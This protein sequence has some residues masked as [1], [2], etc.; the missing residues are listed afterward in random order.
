MNRMSENRFTKSGYRHLAAALVLGVV[1]LCVYYP[2]FRFDYLYHDDWPLFASRESPCSPSL[3]AWDQMGRPG[4]RVV[5]CALYRLFEKIDEAWLA[6]LA[7]VGGIIAFALLQSIYFQVL[8]ISW[9]A[10]VALAFG[11]SVLPGMLVFGYWITAGSIIFS[12][13]PCAAAALLTHASLHPEKGIV[14]RAALISGACALQTVSLLI[15]QAGAMYF[16]TL[17]AVMLAALLSRGLRAAV[18]PLA[19]FTLVG[20]GPMAGYFIWF[21]YLSGWAP[22]L[23]VQDPY[24]GRIFSELS[25][26]ANWF[27]SS[28]LPRAGLLWFF[29]LSRGFGLA[30]LTVFVV[31]LLLLSAYMWLTTWRW[32]DRTGSFLYAAY[33]VVIVVLGVLAFLPMLVTSLYLELFRSFIPL[34]AL[35]FLT[36]TIHLGTILRAASWAPVI[37]TGVAACFVLGLSCLAVDSLVSRMILPAAAEY[38]FVRNSLLEAAEHGR[39]VE[40]VHVVVPRRSLRFSTD[41]I[42]NFTVQDLGTMILVIGRELGLPPRPVSFSLPGEPFEREGALVVDLAELSKSG[43]WKPAIAGEATGDS[44]PLILWA[45]GDYDLVAF[46]GLIYGVPRSLGHVTWEDGM[47]AKL[48]G[49]ISG[50]TVGEVMSRLPTEAAAE[51][52]PRLLRSHRGYNLV[53]YRGQIYGVP[54]AL[55]PVDWAGGRVDQLPGVVTGGTVEEVLARVPR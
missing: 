39:R 52:Q 44:Q 51:S 40:R 3:G 37:K 11:T 47:A 26:S 10:S 13:L 54:Q 2:V 22:V 33:P 19:A 25:T 34:S 20:A 42:D 43:L 29:D 1:L 12:L 14:Q 50:A 8:G 38:S 18:R 4:Q 36:G 6:R 32:G 23:A 15:Y 9:A 28:A 49:V 35:I 7:I 16:W 48:P 5:L 53:A 27:F 24:R 31:S 45:H 41:E 21:R 46:R 30:V 55:G 17:T